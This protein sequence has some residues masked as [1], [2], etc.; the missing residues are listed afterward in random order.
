MIWKEITVLNNYRVII[1]EP[2]QQDIRDIYEYIANTMME[3][4]IANRLVARIRK[5]IAEL[6]NMPERFPFYDKEPWRSN[7]IRRMNIGNFAA[8]YIVVKEGLVVSVLTVIYGK[9]DIESVLT[10]KLEY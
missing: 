1:E 2:A 6:K 4:Q 3:P 5:S 8:F 9:R 7:G 10:E